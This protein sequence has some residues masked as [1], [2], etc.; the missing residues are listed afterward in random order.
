[1]TLLAFIA[2]GFL[3]MIG[4]WLKKWARDEIS[5]GLWDYIRV[6]KKHTIGAVITTLFGVVTAMYS[7][8]DISQ[9]SIGMALLIGFTGDSLVNKA[10]PS[11]Q[12][13]NEYDNH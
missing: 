7:I 11:E 13:V 9:E 8:H 1:M 2:L 5:V 12:P 10:P 6:E 4:H 3:G